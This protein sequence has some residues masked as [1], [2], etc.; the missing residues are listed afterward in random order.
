ML[1]ISAT[2]YTNKPSIVNAET[3][4]SQWNKICMRLCMKH[5]YTHA[6]IFPLIVVSK[7]K[8]TIQIQARRTTANIEGINT[9][10]WYIGY[11]KCIVLL[12]FLFLSLFHLFFLFVFVFVVSRFGC[13]C[14]CCWY[15]STRYNHF[16]YN[17]IQCKFDKHR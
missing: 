10:V 4:K 5:P 14:C 11:I 2:N 1:A 6:P 8:Y 15:R 16:K 3:I 17:W 12:L 9:I 7:S 13:C